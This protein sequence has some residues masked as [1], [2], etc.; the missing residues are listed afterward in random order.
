MAGSG[1]AGSLVAK[2]V[3][4]A[5]QLPGTPL[6]RKSHRRA[7]PPDRAKSP[8]AVA[9][10]LNSPW[11]SSPS[12]ATIIA[13]GVVLSPR[14]PSAPIFLSSRTSVVEVLAWQDAAVAAAGKGGRA[15]HHHG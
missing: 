9:F 13:W 14:P 2:T 1:A 6:H 12:P 5:A 11:S 10:T 15:G 4:T 7:A 8:T 3:L